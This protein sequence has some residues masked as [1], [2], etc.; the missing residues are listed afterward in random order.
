[1]TKQIPEEDEQLRYLLQRL[2]ENNDNKLKVLKRLRA[3]TLTIFNYLIKCWLENSLLTKEEDIIEQ[4]KRW[5]QERTEKELI[6]SPFWQ[7]HL[8]YL[9]PSARLKLAGEVWSDLRIMYDLMWQLERDHYPLAAKELKRA[10]ALGLTVAGEETGAFAKV[11]YTFFMPQAELFLNLIGYCQKQ[12]I[13]CLDYRD[14]ITAREELTKEMP[15][16]I[17][18]HFP[19]GVNYDDGYNQELVHE[20]HVLGYAVQ[21]LYAFLGIGSTDLNHVPICWY[22]TCGGDLE[23]GRFLNDFYEDGGIYREDNLARFLF[24]ANDHP[25]AVKKQF[26]RKEQDALGV[27]QIQGHVNDIHFKF[28]R[29]IKLSKVVIFPEDGM[30]MFKKAGLCSISCSHG[31]GLWMGDIEM[32]K[33]CLGKYIPELRLEQLIVEGLFVFDFNS[34]PGFS[35]L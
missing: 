20:N 13:N 27:W 30:D 21:A 35:K 32:L 29:G 19:K 15:K 8:K 6:W 5:F 16:W 11:N 12:R 28:H 25:V 9:L 34:A 2:G 17:K 4:R 14:T 33:I 24:V 3:R 31:Y 18:S 26:L 10:I 7:P 1:M 23:W 22:R